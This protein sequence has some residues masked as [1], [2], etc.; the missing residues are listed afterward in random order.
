MMFS[1]WAIFT[2]SFM[3]ADQLAHVL[4]PG[5]CHFFGWT[6]PWQLCPQVLYVFVAVVVTCSPKTGPS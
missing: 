4:R 1:P 2:A 6:V 3:P 5:Q